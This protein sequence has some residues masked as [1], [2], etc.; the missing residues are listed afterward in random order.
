[1][2]ALVPT[3]V[4]AIAC[5]LCVAST[6]AWPQA[7][8]IRP[9][10]PEVLALVARYALTSADE[11]RK[12]LL[13]LN[14]IPA[15]PGLQ[16]AFDANQ[17]R[18]LFGFLGEVAAWQPGVA[19]AILLVASDSRVVAEFTEGV[20]GVYEAIRENDAVYFLA[21]L[22]YVDPTPGVQIAELF[23]EWSL[24]A[25]GAPPLCRIVLTDE[26]AANESLVARTLPE[27]DPSIAQ[28][29]LS[30]WQLDRGDVVLRNANGDGLRFERQEL[31][32]RGGTWAKVPERP[33]PLLM[34]RP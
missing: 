4:G 7:P 19:G 6:L 14:P 27:C 31:G 17:C 5:V 22:Q 28:L 15:P 18:P 24:A 29:G 33:R 25:P 21:N 2:A 26:G 9:E 3:R 11:T 34:S 23:G 8:S 10:A 1:M 16:V 32:P 20:G 12:C 13:T 30:T